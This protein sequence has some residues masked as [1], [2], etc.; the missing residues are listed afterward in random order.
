MTILKSLNVHPTTILS[1]ETPVERVSNPAG[2]EVLVFTGEN[3]EEYVLLNLPSTKL[4]VPQVGTTEPS[5]ET[6]K[7]HGVEI[8]VQVSSGT[9]ITNLPPEEEGTLFL[10]SYPTAKA[11]SEAGRK[12]LLN[13]GPLV[14]QS[15]DPETGRGSVILGC[16]GLNRFA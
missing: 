2:R 8:P 11:A 12:D 13:A 5:K 1:E 15:Y 4:P 10:T 14:F 3:I 16:L 9:A 7:V 6:V